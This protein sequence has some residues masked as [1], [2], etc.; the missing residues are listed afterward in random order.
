MLQDT[1]SNITAVLSAH[2]YFRSATHLGK[3]VRLWGKAA[4][5]NEG[6]LTI[7][8][9][10]RMVGR[11]VPLEIGVRPGAKL[12]I[13]E[14]TYINYGCSIGATQLVQ[15]G[16]NCN[17]GTYVIIIDNDFHHLQPERRHEMP[18]S[19]PIILEENVWLG[20]RVVVLRGV[21]IGAG[22]VIGAGSIVNRDIP[23]RTLAAGMPAKVIREL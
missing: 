11:F 6:S 1:V 18:E 7:A 4:V 13:G 14:S 21:T 5:K 19:A 9:R 3:K 16:P 23:P 10:V 15:I 8:D 2:W 22:S 12:T 20:A 17:I